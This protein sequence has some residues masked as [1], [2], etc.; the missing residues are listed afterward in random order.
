MAKRKGPVPA[1]NTASLQQPLGPVV[2]VIMAGD[3]LAVSQ[4]T[5]RKGRLRPSWTIIVSGDAGPYSLTVADDAGIRVAE[6]LRVGDFVITEA[7]LIPRGAQCEIRTLLLQSNRESRLPVVPVKASAV[8]AIDVSEDES[9][10]RLPWEETG[11]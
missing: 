1:R 2:K 7:T 11:S 9:E 3:V 10:D 5:K 8:R 6:R 4:I